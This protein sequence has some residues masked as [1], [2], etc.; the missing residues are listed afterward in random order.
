M[1][2]WTKRALAGVIGLGL[3]A[4][5]GAAYQWLATRRDLAATPPPGQLVD[6]GG[7]RLHLWCMG[8][9]AAGGRPGVRTRRRRFHVAAG[10]ER[11]S[12]VH[13]RLRVSTARGWDTAIR[14]RSRVRAAGSHRNSRGAGW[15]A[16]AWVLTFN[17]WSGI[18]AERAPVRLSL[19]QKAD[20]FHFVVTIENHLGEIL[21]RP[22]QSDAPK[23][24]VATE[25]NDH[26]WR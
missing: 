9:G 11:N 7:Y 10:P 1:W 8:A 17:D 20:A 21:V 26:R 12:D 13:S 24:L 16:S 4:A 18:R 5:L 6:I 14:R 19:R 22:F 2:R 23:V 15:A 3:I 25:A